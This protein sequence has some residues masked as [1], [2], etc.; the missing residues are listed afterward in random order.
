MALEW[1]RPSGGGT[2]AGTVTGRSGGLGLSLTRYREGTTQRHVSRSVA[3]VA[4]D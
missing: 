2:T 3:E 1:N 4:S